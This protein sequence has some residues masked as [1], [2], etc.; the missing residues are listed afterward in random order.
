MSYGIAVSKI[1]LTEEETK[2]KINTQKT[3]PDNTEFN[4]RSFKSNI[5]NA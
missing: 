1:K 3:K 2:K 4:D 5:E